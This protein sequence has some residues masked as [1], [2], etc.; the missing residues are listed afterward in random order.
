MTA[1]VG[2]SLRDA[3]SRAKSSALRI[4]CSSDV[5]RSAA[6]NTW[7]PGSLS[8]GKCRL[9]RFPEGQFSLWIA[10]DDDVVALREFPLEH[11]QRQRVLQQA[12]DRPLE[13]PRAE[14]RIIAFRC[15]HLT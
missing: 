13:W 12:L 3:A 1:P 5:S 4:Y 11:R 6:P 10:V 2:E 9:G 14:S 8:I 15:Q 7:V